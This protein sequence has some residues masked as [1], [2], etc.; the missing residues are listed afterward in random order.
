MHAAIR[1]YEAIDRT[2]DRLREERLATALPNPPKITNGVDRDQLSAHSWRGLLPA[3]RARRRLTAAA[4]A[5]ATR[6]TAR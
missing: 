5:D 2:G 3:I 6:A 1:R 4:N